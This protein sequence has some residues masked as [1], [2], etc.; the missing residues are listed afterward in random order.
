MSDNIGYRIAHP[1]SS[2][3]CKEIKKK[4]EIQACPVNL[5]RPSMWPHLKVNTPLWTTELWYGDHRDLQRPWSSFHFTGEKTAQCTSDGKW[6]SYFKVFLRFL[7]KVFH[8][9]A[10]AWTSAKTGMQTRRHPDRGCFSSLIGLLNCMLVGFPLYM[11][12]FLVTHSVVATG[13]QHVRKW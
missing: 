13:E 4:K 8:L 7:W 3:D 10:S 5:V 6:D 9:N 1:C 2:H 12:G 11:T